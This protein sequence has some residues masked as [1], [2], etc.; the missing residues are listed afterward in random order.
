[1]LL[2]VLAQL[3]ASYLKYR[4]LAALI[5][6]EAMACQNIFIWGVRTAQYP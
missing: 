3:K 5:S 4:G 6:I 1:M 2:F